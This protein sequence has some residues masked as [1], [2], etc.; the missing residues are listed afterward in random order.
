[1]AAGGNERLTADSAK[2]AK[3]ESRKGSKDAKNSIHFWLA[4][5]ASL[6]DEIFMSFDSSNSFLAK[7]RVLGHDGSSFATNLPAE[8]R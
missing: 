7:G 4:S 1:M 5:F 2:E 6:R 3:K 8:P